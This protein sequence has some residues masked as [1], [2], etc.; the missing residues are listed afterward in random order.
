MENDMSVSYFGAP[1]SCPTCGGAIETYGEYLICSNKYDCPA[2]I[3]GQI[4]RWIGGCGVKHFGGTTIE[5]LVEQG[6]ISCIADIYDLTKDGVKEIEINGRKI[7]SSLDRGLDSLHANKE[8]TLDQFI[9]SLGI[10]MIGSSMIRMMM[11]AG[12]DELSK[13]DTL[14]EEEVAKVP[15]YSTEKAK[16]LVE[17]FNDRRNTMLEILSAGV[18][19]VKPEVVEQTGSSLDGKVFC[20]TGVRDA[21]LKAKIEA[22]GGKFASGVSSKVHYL[23]C[24]DTSSTSGKAKKARDLGLTLLSLNDAWD[25]VK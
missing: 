6:Y 11:A 2:Q 12:Y 4:S 20:I 14:T 25:L 3:V 17:G 1:T 22:E 8:I 24:K 23:I 10:N 18:S 16:Y 7:G 19:I 13:F 21:A 15:G 5:G 9:G